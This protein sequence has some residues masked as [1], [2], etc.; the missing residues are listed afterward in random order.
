VKPVSS[1]VSTPSPRS[2][3]A[4]TFNRSVKPVSF[5]VSTSS[6]RSDQG[7]TSN[8]SSKSASSTTSTQSSERFQREILRRLEE[9]KGV[10]DQ[11]KE[12]QNFVAQ[13]SMSSLD[14]FPRVDSDS[15]WAAL[16][17]SL[18]YEETRKQLVG[19]NDFWFSLFIII[20]SATQF[21]LLAK[22]CA[23][24]HRESIRRMWETI[25]TTDFGTTL[26]WEGRKK[27]SKIAVRQSRIFTLTKGI[28]EC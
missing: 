8:R 10:V 5:A 21:P 20:L 25:V 1:A 23:T 11:I 4:G 12:N 9:I 27:N 15:S 2:D 19:F 26:T 3:K 18:K 13:N 28:M 14:S 17:Q 24:D 22:E 6:P 16:E 7:G